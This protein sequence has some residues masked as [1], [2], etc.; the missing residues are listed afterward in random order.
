MRETSSCGGSA[1]ELGET[2]AGIGADRLTTVCGAGGGASPRWG[3]FAAASATRPLPREALVDA[4]FVVDAAGRTSPARRRTRR[5]G[6]LGSLDAESIVTDDGP[7]EAP[8]GEESGLCL[9]K[10][11]RVALH[12]FVIVCRKVPTRSGVAAVVASEGR[13]C[14][15]RAAVSTAT[16]GRA[17]SHALIATAAIDAATRPMARRSSDLGSQRC[18]ERRRMVCAVLTIAAA[19]VAAA[20]II[21]RRHI[22]PIESPII[23]TADARLQGR[24]ATTLWR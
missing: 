18:G 14:V 21:Q 24:T 8:A 16:G 9:D 12:P 17:M 6:G 20:M 15:C 23:R 11:S 7:M 10:K 13:S 4:R 1:A 2:S 22:E 3:L 19:T 5:T